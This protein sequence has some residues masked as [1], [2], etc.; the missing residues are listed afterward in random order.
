MKVGSSTVL[1]NGL[2][3]YKMGKF[4]VRK[5]TTNKQK[6]NE[7]LQSVKSK[8]PKFSKK[9]NDANV[10]VRKF[11]ESWKIQ[12]PWVVCENDTMFCNM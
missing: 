7:N 11:Q 5:D 12:F 2:L 4:V 10:R 8:G 3:G 6:A 1:V 9:S